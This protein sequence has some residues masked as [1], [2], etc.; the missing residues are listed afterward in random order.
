MLLANHEGA[1]KVGHQAA[2]EFVKMDPFGV[3]MAFIAMSIVFSVL[4]IIYL[5]F[6][7]ISKG[8]L[9]FQTKTIKKRENNKIIEITPEAVE[10]EVTAAI[11]MALHLYRTRQHDM[12]SLKMTIQKVSKMYSP[13]SSKLY[14]LTQTPRK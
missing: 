3:G 11:S 1:V 5:I 10:A 7:Y 2:D 13:W 4:A 6:K 8:Y 9:L 14:M 12:E